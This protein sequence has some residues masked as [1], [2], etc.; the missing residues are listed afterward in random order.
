MTQEKLD[1][2]LRVALIGA[3]AMGSAIAR[4]LVESG[5]LAAEQIS[6]CD[7]NQNKLDAL[8]SCGIQTYAAYTK[9]D[10]D[11]FF[12]SGADVVIIA[13][14][15]QSFPSFEASFDAFSAAFAN[16]LVISI[17]AGISL[18]TLSSMFCESRVIRAMPNLP[19]A[20]LSGATALCAHE[21]AL[22]DTD[23]PLA[24]S[25]FGALGAAAFMRED[26]LDAEG[27]VVGCGPAYFALMIDELT[28]T[29]VRCGMKASDARAMSLATM[30]GVALMLEGQE[31]HPRAYMEKVTS[32][33][34]TTAAALYKL[35]PALK[36]GI[37][38]AI[39]NALAR[40]KELSGE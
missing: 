21:D 33:G 24:L 16:K 26:Q 18:S 28:N 35:E 38:D 11:E 29:A 13:I 1:A 20:V 15:P 9:P 34:G 10:S 36:Q 37:D 2:Q 14:K 6:I 30:K 40:T 4:G 22:N 25:L 39:D 27:A 19:V 32:P 7:H 12:F 31:E 17:A 3:G 23:K 5:A 8:A